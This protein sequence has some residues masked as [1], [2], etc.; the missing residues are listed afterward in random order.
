MNF[1]DDEHLGGS[2]FKKEVSFGCFNFFECSEF[3]HPKSKILHFQLVVL[4]FLDF[5]VLFVFP[6]HLLLKAAQ[7][8]LQK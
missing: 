8:L 6:A 3:D 4:V 7:Y 2:C 1:T 5:L